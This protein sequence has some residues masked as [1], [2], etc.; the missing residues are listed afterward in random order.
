MW[1]RS[2]LPLT[3][4]LV[5]KTDPGEDYYVVLKDA[6]TGKAAMAA[7]ARGGDFFRVLV[8]PGTFRIAIAAG[9]GW[10][11]EE[12]LFGPGDATRRFELPDTL[13][14]RVRGLATKAG[15]VVDLREAPAGV[16]A[17]SRVRAAE[18]CGR[19]MLVPG[20][21]LRAGDILIDPS[22]GRYAEGDGPI[23][24]NP[25]DGPIGAQRRDGPLGADP[26]AGRRAE[27]RAPTVE[28]YTV[29]CG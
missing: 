16:L 26:M 23:G 2:G 13:T 20:D 5:L 15:H 21:P 7:Y 29:D 10:E 9:T 3:F 24:A 11:G 6:G 25:T 1:N 19:V 8:P 18:I 4:P 28:S 12:R 17:S 22:D 14:F 27:R